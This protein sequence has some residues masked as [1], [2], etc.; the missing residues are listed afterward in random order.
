MNQD[1]V[2]TT[3]AP[4][5]PLPNLF[6]VADGMGGHKGGGVASSVAVD[7]MRRVIEASKE[8]DPERILDDA[9]LMANSSVRKCAGESDEL[10]GMGTT[11]VLATII[12]DEL[13]VA[14]I[15]D[16]RLYV[17]GQKIEQIT[18][19]HSYVEE[20]VKMGTLDRE[21][22]RT[23]PK[24]NIITRAIGAAEVAQADF[25]KVKLKPGDKILMCTDGLTNMI[26]DEDIR[27]IINSKRDIVEM[28]E[29]LVGRAN[30][31][32]GKDNISVILVEPFV[33]ENR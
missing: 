5:G 18:V 6:I 27:R 13:Y 12:D 11:A 26:E 2:F 24:K 17:V 7:V 32:G 31:N 3:E 8:T 1:F 22:A 25:F 30:E 16:S 23:H 9:V 14:N 28:A 4:I 33:D 20:L 15:G 21:M 19:D 10:T 29:G